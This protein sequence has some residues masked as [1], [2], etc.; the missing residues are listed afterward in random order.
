MIEEIIALFGENVELRAGSA[1]EA[2]SQNLTS[3]TV[4]LSWMS[5]MCSGTQSHTEMRG[6]R[7][8]CKTLTRRSWLQVRLHF[9]IIDWA[10]LGTP[11]P[12]ISSREVH[13]VIMELPILINF[14]LRW[15]W[16]LRI[17]KYGVLLHVCFFN[18]ERAAEQKPDD[19]FN[20]VLPAELDIARPPS[21]GK[22]F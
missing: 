21:P 6:L 5:T 12:K 18:E 4:S 22:I 20:Y 1:K 2:F 16:K 9:E 11:F 3:Y 17:Q 14:P 13:I 15:S 7:V 19:I 8:L 10:R